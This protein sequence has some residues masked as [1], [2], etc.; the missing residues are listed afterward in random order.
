MLSRPAMA[1]VISALA[2]CSGASSSPSA[3]RDDGANV[4]KP[5]PTPTPPPPTTTADPRIATGAAAYGKYC[6]LCHGP[7]A[8]GYAAD[9][10]P[11]L[12]TRTFLETADDVFLGKSIELGRPGTPMAAYG[13]D[14]GGPLGD[15][16]IA[17]IIA[18]LRDKGGVP[19]AVPVP[20]PLPGDPARGQPL[21]VQHCQSCHGDA[22][23]RSTGPHLANSVFR[24]VASPGFMR[25]AIVFGRPGTPMLPFADKLDGNQV[26]DVI[27]YVQ[28]LGQPAPT[29]HE[30]VAPPAPTGP[31]VINPKG[32]APT[33]TLREGRFVPSAEVAAALKKKQRIVI[34][35]A[36]PPSD[37][38]RERIPGSISV[39]HY[40]TSTLD[41]VPNDGT[42]VIAYCACPHHASGVVV[43]ELRKRGYKNTAVLDEGVLFWAKQKYPVEGT[44]GPAPDPHAGHSHHG[45]AH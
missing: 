45:H 32:K 3:Q 25:Y 5:T 14:L 40:D 39:P 22:T 19:A 6:A 18:F 41:R 28:S 42:W 13:K 34:I 16:E 10:A 35:D 26:A 4:S 43:D 1:L 12:V 11:S 29:K 17:A 21:Y 38:L 20:A 24:A 37:W 31:V 8:K 33:F 27:A 15:E 30:P 7:E 23:T 9:N 36:R 44:G 2:A